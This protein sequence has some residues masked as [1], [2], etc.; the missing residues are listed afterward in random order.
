MSPLRLSSASPRIAT[1]L[2]QDASIG[3][4]RYVSKEREEAFLRIDITTVRELLLSLPY[5]YIDV[6]SVTP[7]ARSMMAQ[8]TTVFGVVDLIKTKTPRPRFSIVEVFIRDASGVLCLTFFRQPWVLQKLKVGDGIIATGTISM[9]AGFK[10]ISSPLYEVVYVAEKSNGAQGKSGESAGAK[11]GRNAAAKPGRNANLKQES[12][13]GTDIPKEIKVRTPVVPI[14]HATE[15]LSVGWLRR[16]MSEAVQVYGNRLDFVP[17]SFIV[18]N[19]LMT[20]GNA[21][22]QAHFP[23]SLTEAARARKRL[24]YDELLCLQLALRTRKDLLAKH[25]LAQSHKG[26][27][28]IQKPGKLFETLQQ[29]LPFQLTESQEAALSSIL[30]DME[31]ENQMHRLLLGDV[32]SGKTIIA[33]FALAAAAD[34]GMQG[35]IMAPTSV[36]AFQYAEKLGPLFDAAN[37]TWCVLTGATPLSEREGLLEKIEK[38]EINVVFGTT[39]ILS[40]DVT[41]KDLSF[42]VVDEQHRFGV[43]QR[44]LLSKKG[45]GPDVLSMSATPI[46]RTLALS[47]YGDM[48]VTSLKGRPVAGAGISSTIV[49]QENLDIAYKAINEA[50]SA[51]QQAYVICPL[52]EPQETHPQDLQEDGFNLVNDPSAPVVR[53]T[54]KSSKQTATANLT[55]ALPTFER[56]KSTIAP[57]AK[58]GLLTGRMTGPE[59]D[60][61][62]QDFYDGKIQILVS[63]TVVEVGVDVPNA[64]CMLVM[65]ADRF[66]LATLHQLRGRV[67]R[68]EI[69]GKVFFHTCAKKNSK[70]RHRLDLLE[71][72]DDGAELAERDLKLRPAGDRLGYR[73][74]G[75]ATLRL[76]D[77]AEDEDII[78]AARNDALTILSSEAFLK[79]SLAIP[80]IHEIKERY[81]HYFDQSITS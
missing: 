28:K 71:K 63:T 14:H 51:G 8:K 21:L 55:A 67:G 17:A 47:I 72:T 5:R 26:S 56:F 2:T 75:H 45:S 34:S 77:L 11:P 54:K 20:E 9:N 10:Q 50:V 4:L 78:A 30:R 32:G 57:N 39:A 58:V 76:V 69:S 35:A 23:S 7:I 33:A 3:S 40:E 43:N 12:A 64:T 46:P 70:A 24:A 1:S 62:M 65:D 66:G 36:L 37:I 60:Q 42:V 6:S 44:A 38:G 52:I 18:K 79:S 81:K 53:S 74:S 80:L 27:G 16:I 59:K 41:F 48:D 49:S 68:G 19:R 29:K 15:G 73:Q 31:S 13:A 61:V 25:Q 22:R